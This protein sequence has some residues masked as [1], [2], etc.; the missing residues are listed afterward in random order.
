M[1]VSVVLDPGGEDSARELASIMS[2]YGFKRVQRS[3]WES[4][5]IAPAALAGLKRDIDRVTDYY[6]TVRMYQFPVDNVLAV[7]E[8][9]RKRWKKILVRPPVPGGARR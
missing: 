8:L 5:G 4:A 2:G 7:T 9:C 3:C 6:D 1:F